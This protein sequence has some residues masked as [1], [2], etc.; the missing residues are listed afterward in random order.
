M[1]HLCPLI[2]LAETQEEMLLPRW[3][4]GAQDW[5]SSSDTHPGPQ[6]PG[7]SQSKAGGQ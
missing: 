3:G 2:V 7:P 6:R 5:Q 1:A 4:H